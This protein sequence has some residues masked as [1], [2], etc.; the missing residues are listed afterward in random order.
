MCMIHWAV[1]SVNDSHV[2]FT[3]Y[4]VLYTEVYFILSRAKKMKKKKSLKKTFI[5]V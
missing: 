1:Q 3:Y 5:C 4:T 2:L